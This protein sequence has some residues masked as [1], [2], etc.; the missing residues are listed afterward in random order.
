MDHD[1][2][3][4]SRFELLQRINWA[5]WLRTRWILLGICMLTAHVDLVLLSTYF[6]PPNATSGQSGS[7]SNIRYIL[8]GFIQVFLSPSAELLS[9]DR[10]QHTLSSPCCLATCLIYYSARSL[11]L[12][13]SCHERRSAPLRTWWLIR[14]LRLPVPMG[15]ILSHGSPRM[16]ES[17]PIVTIPIIWVSRHIK[18]RT[19]R[20]MA[21]ISFCKNLLLTGNASGMQLPTL[22]H[23]SPPSLKPSPSSHGRSTT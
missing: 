8:L 1:A 10:T 4:L 9:T 16:L 12:Q 13:P 15:T 21:L 5:G 14:P 20:N 19:T 6:G 22:R 17:T 3:H 2:F 11:Q 7:Y 23:R 18:A